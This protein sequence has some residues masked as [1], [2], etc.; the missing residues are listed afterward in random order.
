MNFTVNYLNRYTFRELYVYTPKSRRHI[1]LLQ[2]YKAQ[3]KNR[4]YKR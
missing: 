1:A 4:K 3:K 2:L